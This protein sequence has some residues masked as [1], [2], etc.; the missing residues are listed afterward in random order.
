MRLAAGIADLL[1]R[2]FG[3]GAVQ[4]DHGHLCAFGCQHARSGT[5]HASGRAGDEGTP[6]LQ[7]TCSAQRVEPRQLVQRI[8]PPSTGLVS[9][10]A[11]NH[12]IGTLQPIGG[13]AAVARAAGA[14][15]HTDAAQAAGKVPLDVNAMGVDLLSLTGHKYYGPKGAGA[16]YIRRR[17]PR[18]QLACQID[19]GRH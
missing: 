3:A 5:A 1:C 9:V 11:A 7:R 4:V 8:H 17:K 2:G 15:L 14:F 18:I 12:E 16:P 6:P 10:M 19:G 13:I